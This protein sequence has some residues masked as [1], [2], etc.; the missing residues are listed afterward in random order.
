MYLL[1]QLSYVWVYVSCLGKASSS[2]DY[3][4]LVFFVNWWLYAVSDMVMVSKVFQ[5]PK[6]QDYWK[7]N[8]EQT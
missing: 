4:E 8:S 7:V 6:I 3:L 1:L 5:I 2:L